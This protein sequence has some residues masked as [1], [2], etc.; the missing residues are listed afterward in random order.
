MKRGSDENGPSSSHRP[1]KLRNSEHA[2]SK[3]RV[4]QIIFKY[5]SIDLQSFRVYE[6]HVIIELTMLEE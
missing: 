2:Y 6:I 4:I 3:I 5:S 1:L